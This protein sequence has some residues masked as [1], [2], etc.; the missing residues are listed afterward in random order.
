MSKTIIKFFCIYLITLPIFAVEKIDLIS[1]YR[2][3]L[4]ND[5]TLA[6]QQATFMALG[7]VRPLAIANLLP[8]IATSADW[9]R[10]YNNQLVNNSTNSTTQ[11]TNSKYS[12]AYTLS[13]EQP[14]F[15]L[16]KWQ[17]LTKAN[18]QV[19]RNLAILHDQFQEFIIRVASSYINVLRSMDN[20]TL[21]QSEE[22]SFKRQLTQTQHRFQVGLET[23]TSVHSA[24]AAH[25]TAI[26]K[27]IE[28]TNIL[29][30]SISFLSVLSGKNYKGIKT[31]RNHIPLAK[32]IPLNYKKWIIKTLT[33]NYTLLAAQYDKEISKKNISIARSKYL[34]TINATANY[35]DTRFSQNNA[36]PFNRSDSKYRTANIN[37]KFSLPIFNGGSTLA[38][39]RKSSHNYA[40]AFAKYDGIRRNLENQTLQTYNKI[41]SRFH[42]INAL[43]QAVKSA[44]SA[45]TST[46]ESYKQGASTIVDLLTAQKDVFLAKQALLSNIY[47]YLLD[48]LALKK[49]AGTLSEEDLIA[50]N[51]YLI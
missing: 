45:N 32:P 10:N 19:K 18:T 36:N 15:D 23:K 14:I 4:M 21:A 12:S 25:D 6:S 29:E 16:V 41:I 34:P 8:V 39:T 43:K 33:Q 11:I 26:A 5:T 38:N 30:N 42:Q 1:L 7:E 51:K 27:T 2:D 40:V 22:K 35:I 48:S 9:N 17:N 44:E 49:L 47:D 31:F 28:Q 3:S 20:L 37:L 46:S 50:L 13:I 24:K